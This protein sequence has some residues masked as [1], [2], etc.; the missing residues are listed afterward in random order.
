MDQVKKTLHLHQSICEIVSAP[1]G[2]LGIY[3]PVAQT[4]F[5]QEYQHHFHVPETLSD[6]S[7]FN[8]FGQNMYK[9]PSSELQKILFQH[10]VKIRRMFPNVE[11]YKTFDVWQEQYQPSLTAKSVNGN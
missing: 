11:S 9:T 4:S 2:E 7:K 6:W 5:F 8:Y 10:H 1:T 3:N